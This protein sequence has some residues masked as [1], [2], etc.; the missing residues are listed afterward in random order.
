MNACEH[1]KVPQSGFSENTAAADTERAAALAEKPAFGREPLVPLPVMNWRARR[2]K[3]RIRKA[4][5]PCVGER[6][7]LRARCADTMKE[8]YEAF[9]GVHRGPIVS[10]GPDGARP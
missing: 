6:R 10:K 8:N 2:G 7:A 3:A 4:R 5:S 9:A 1:A